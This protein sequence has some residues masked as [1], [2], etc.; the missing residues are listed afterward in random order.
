MLPIRHPIQ[1]ESP[2][3]GT[4][5]PNRAIAPG[6]LCYQGKRANRYAFQYQNALE[7]Y[8]TV[9][10]RAATRAILGT[11][12][13]FAAFATDASG[14]VPVIIDSPCGGAGFFLTGSPYVRGFNLDDVNTT[15]VYS[16]EL[17]WIGIDPETWAGA[18]AYSGNPVCGAAGNEAAVLVGEAGSN[19]Y[20]VKPW[21]DLSF[22]T[23]TASLVYNSI[24]TA[25]NRTKNIVWDPVAEY[26]WLRLGA[27]IY[28]IDADGEASTWWG[29]VGTGGDD[30]VSRP[31]MAAYSNAIFVAYCAEG[32]GEVAIKIKA[33][34]EGTTT[35]VDAPDAAL[36]NDP[37]GYDVSPIAFQYSPEIGWILVLS[38]GEI[39]T[40]PDPT[41]GVWTAW[42]TAFSSIKYYGASQ[43]W[44]FGSC[45][46][47]EV[48]HAEYGYESPKYSLAVTEDLGT[49]W[50]LIRAPVEDGRASRFT[51]GGRYLYAVIADTSAARI[52]RCGPVAG[53][54]SASILG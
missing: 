54:D 1:A 25:S 47:I 34:D 16:A 22:H 44:I 19:N 12:T 42:G 15:L 20:I 6:G 3:T 9:A 13:P 35:F 48:Q 7:Y 37:G 8:L 26:F 11:W 43:G 50:S 46:A 14:Q 38:T 51:F 24:E 18:G 32:E 21:K 28:R 2:D 30:S 4:G 33:Y 23:S 17:G 10:A 27:G 41:G 53:F 39:F 40:T 52:F 49:T 5:A 45:V 29:P 31:L 36:V